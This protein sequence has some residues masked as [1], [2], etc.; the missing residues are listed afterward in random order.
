MMAQ[1][2]T[3]VIYTE[4]MVTMMAITM[5]TETMVTNDD[6]YNVFKVHMVTTCDV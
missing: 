6:S 1:M 5:Y 4:T 2:M 3:I